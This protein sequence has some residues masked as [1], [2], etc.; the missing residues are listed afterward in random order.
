MRRPH[1]AFALIVCLVA[2][3]A[4]LRGSVAQTSAKKDA[5]PRAGENGYTRPKCLHCHKPPYSSEAYKRK[6]DGPV[7]LDIVVGTDGR[8]HDV[9][10]ARG[11][12]YGLDEEA[13]KTVRDKWRFKPANGPDGKPAAVRILVEIDFHLY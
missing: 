2:I 6:I 13:L 7:M 11:L 8:A 10:I 1:Y 12:G 3:L 5:I 9:H 4:C